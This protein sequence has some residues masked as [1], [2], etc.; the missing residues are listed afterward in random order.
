MV[1]SEDHL[2]EQG[3]D[4]K[5]TLQWVLKKWVGMTQIRFIW[6]RVGTGGG[7][8]CTQWR[9]FKFHKM[10]GISFLSEN[11]LTS[12]ESYYMEFIKQ[13]CSVKPG[14]VT[15]AS[16]SCQHPNHFWPRVQCRVR[17][18]AIF[19]AVNQN[20]STLG[21]ET[22]YTCYG[23]PQSQ[24]VECYL[25]ISVILILLYVLHNVSNFVCSYKCVA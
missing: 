1:K 8:L 23:P 11:S 14:L 12:Q 3:V 7:L 25:N 13:W 16:S 20:T 21:I 17:P 10:H 9:N 22:P 4:G 2:E 18:N 19:D 15:F 6:L 24:V 5:M